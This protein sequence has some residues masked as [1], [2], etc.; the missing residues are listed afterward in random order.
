MLGDLGFHREI[1]GNGLVLLKKGTAQVPTGWKS[2]VKLKDNVATRTGL[3]KSD[4]HKFRL[5][6]SRFLISHLTFNVCEKCKGWCLF[7]PALD[8]QSKDVCIWEW[9]TWGSVYSPYREMGSGNSPSLMQAP[10]LGRA[11][12]QEMLISH[13]R[14]QRQAR[15]PGGD[16]ERCAKEERRFQAWYHTDLRAMLHTHEAWVGSSIN[17][18]VS[19]CTLL[20]CPW[21]TLPAQDKHHLEVKSQQDGPGQ[22]TAQWCW[23][24]AARALLAF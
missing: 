18:A 10:R 5:E 17:S 19:D 12:I 6:S 9:S 3:Y 14:L 20:R 2:N 24:E 22:N 23:A 1:K 7:H 15:V 21:E 11:E 16:G 13:R 8:V 4:I